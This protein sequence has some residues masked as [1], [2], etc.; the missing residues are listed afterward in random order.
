MQNSEARPEEL[1]E[2]NAL[3]YSSKAHWG[4]S[5]D[6]M[7]LWWP[8][9]KLTPNHL[10]EL[11][12]FVARDDSKRLIG[13]FG[14]REINDEDTSQCLELEYFFLSPEHIGK[15]QGTAQSCLT[16]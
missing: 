16:R 3:I 6:L 7:A 11:D 9:L 2:L 8:D 1:D 15:G 13:I 12:I 5:K 14:L 4:Y 10:H